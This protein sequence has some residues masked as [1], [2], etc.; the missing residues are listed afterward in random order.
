VHARN[1][2]ARSQAE[3]GDFDSARATADESLR[4]AE[5]L[6]HTMTLLVARLDACHVLLCRGHFHDAVPQ[7]EACLD[8]FRSASPSIW[9]STAAAMLGY[10]R[11]MTG[12]PED[13]IPFLREALEQLAQSRRT[14]E[15]LFTTYLCEAHLLARQ[16]GE[17]AVVAGRAL[18]L[19][20]ERFERATEARALYLPG[21]S[22][23]RGAEDHVADR[24]CSGALP[25]PLSS[26]SAHSSPTAMSASSI[27]IREQLRGDILIEHQQE[28]Y[29][30]LDSC[31]A[32]SIDSHHLSDRSWLRP[33]GR[34]QC[35]VTGAIARFA[36]S[37]SARAES[38]RSATCCGRPSC[39]NKC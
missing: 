21:E 1:R 4:I 25:W 30:R 27:C 6:Q 36:R 15:A 17:A 13:G 24:H 39:R 14:M 9:V 28:A 5:A 33:A 19:S 26:A 23:A 16:L 38:L 20:R 35:R 18:A 32:A 29:H 12:Q 11:A 37:H 2:L 10:A 34:A 7:L 3:L 8:A 31:G 22:A